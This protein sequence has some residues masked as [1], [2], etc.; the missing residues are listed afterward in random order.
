M[1]H[2][3]SQECVLC[4]RLSGQLSDNNR[5]MIHMRKMRLE[6]ED[7][8]EEAEGKGEAEQAELAEL[9]RVLDQLTN[10][11]R[12]HPLPSP[13]TSSLI[14]FLQTLCLYFLYKLS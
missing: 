5:R 2:G 13:R 9:E 7:A 12:W 1:W 10:T 3:V 6:A 11:Q 14:L 8:L 4:E